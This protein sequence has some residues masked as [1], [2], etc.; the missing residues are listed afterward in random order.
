MMVCCI[1][2]LCILL[3]IIPHTAFT[4]RRYFLSLLRS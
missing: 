2:Q 1:Q 3:V 4:C